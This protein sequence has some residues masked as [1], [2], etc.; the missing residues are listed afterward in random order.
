MLVQRIPWEMV[1][2]LSAEQAFD[3]RLPGQTEVLGDVAQ[4]AG[5]RAHPEGRVT[6]DGHVVL[7]TS[8]VVSRTWP[9]V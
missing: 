9:P 4:D 6:R 2:A 3:Q 1:I 5:Q 7:T 8:E